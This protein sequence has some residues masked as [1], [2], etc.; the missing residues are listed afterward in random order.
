MITLIGIG[1]VFSIR[2]TVK[3]IIYQRSPDAVCVELDKFRFE[4]LDKGLDRSKDAPFL[5]KRLQKVYDKAAQTQGAQV[6]EEMLGAVEAA[7]K[8]EIPHFFIDVEATP[9]VSGILDGLSITQKLKLAGSV[10]GASVLPKKQLEKGMDLIEQDPDRAMKEFGKVFPELKERIVD[11]RD[12]YMS[13]KLVALNRE[14]PHLLAVIGQGH[15]KGITSHL[16]RMDLD[17]I[18]LKDCLLYT[19]PSPRDRQKSRMPSSA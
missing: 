15:M 3:Y 8:L 11:Y 16:Q 5:M 13:R 19:S 12:T 14:Y 4:I 17:V 6:G 18:N 7:K 10:L 1:H 2:D 9:M